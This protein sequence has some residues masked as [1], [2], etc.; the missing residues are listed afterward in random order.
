MKMVKCIMGH[1]YNAEK[2]SVCPHCA[3]MEAEAQSATT[4]EEVIGDVDTEEPDAVKQQKYE[5]VGRRKVV[6]CLVCTKG[7]MMGEGFFLVEGHNDIGRGANLE[8]VLSKELTV[9][10]KAHACITYEKKE[11]RYYLVAAEGKKD[12]LYN[13]VMVE[14]AVELENGGELQIGQ[15]G[16]R[17]VAFCDENFSWKR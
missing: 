13:G 11:N 7:S 14:Q 2:F 3:S 6:G 9:S 12:V 15:C 4:L 10:R 1:K 17:F 5:I 16:L 8:V